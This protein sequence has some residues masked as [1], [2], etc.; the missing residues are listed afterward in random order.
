MNRIIMLAFSAGLLAL[1]AS[2]GQA[3]N[4][5]TGQSAVDLAVP[6]IQMTLE[7]PMAARVDAIIR[8]WLIP[9]PDANPGMLKMMRLRDHSSASQATTATDSRFSGLFR[10]RTGSAW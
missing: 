6:R 4:A 9:A 1:A 8:N 2:F 7:G 5:S 3:N 10:N